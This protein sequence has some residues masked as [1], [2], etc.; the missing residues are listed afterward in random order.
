MPETT[1]DVRVDSTRHRS[2]VLVL[3]AGEEPVVCGHG[4]GEQTESS[5]GTHTSHG[6]QEPPLR[7]AVHDRQQQQHPDSHHTLLLLSI[8]TTLPLSPASHPRT[9]HHRP[10]QIAP[11]PP[12][13]PQRSGLES[14]LLPLCCAARFR[15]RSGLLAV[16]SA[17]TSGL[18]LHDYTT[19]RVTSLTQ[20]STDRTEGVS[21]LSPFCTSLLASDVPGVY[22]D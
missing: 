5:A 3:L 4:D 2:V 13:F 19:R 7:T 8:Q 21:K 6:G 15:S 18:R 11:P 1:V 9:L 12:P 16:I 20:V 10:L 14:V 22:N 17:H